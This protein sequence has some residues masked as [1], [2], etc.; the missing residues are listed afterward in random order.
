MTKYIAVPEELLQ[1]IAKC[2]DSTIELK[3]VD[4]DQPPEPATEWDFNAAQLVWELRALLDG[5]GVEPVAWLM[6]NKYGDEI[7]ITESNLRNVQPAWV[8]ELWK[9]AKPLYLAAPSAPVQAV[10]DLAKG[11]V[12]HILRPGAT[13]CCTL[14]I[15]EVTKSTALFRSPGYC[16]EERL[17]IS[18]VRFVELLAAAPQ[19]PATTDKENGE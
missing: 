7:S 19:P 8:Q 5:P 14:E 4:F 1:Q 16:N 12:W 18:D 17:P 11:Q 6:H 15:V 2:I 13:A 3:Q 9:D 10:P